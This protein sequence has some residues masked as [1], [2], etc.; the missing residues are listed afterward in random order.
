MGLSKE[1]RWVFYKYQIIFF[2]R[3]MNTPQ[4]LVYRTICDF[5]RKVLVTDLRVIKSGWV[6]LHVLK[7]YFG[8]LKES[9]RQAS[10]DKT[11]KRIAIS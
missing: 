1:I 10:F 7:K 3:L 2:F 11:S 8:S 4:C 9:N 5:G 6:F